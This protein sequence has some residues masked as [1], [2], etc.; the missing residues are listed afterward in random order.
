MRALVDRLTLISG[1]GAP[2]D[3]IRPLVDGLATEVTAFS[4]DDSLLAG[5]PSFDAA[6]DALLDRLGDREWLVGWSLGGL[7]AMAIA[8]RAPERIAGVITLCT[9]PCFVAREAGATGMAPDTFAGFRQ[10]LER[11]AARQWQRFMLLQV[12][13]A[14]AGRQALDSWLTS[15]PPA[16][17]TV[18]IHS[19]AWL[20]EVD[21]RQEWAEVTVPTLH[22]FGRRD[23]LVDPACAALLQSQGRPVRLL[24]NLYHWP[25]GDAATQVRRAIEDCLNEYRAGQAA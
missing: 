16:S 20:A 24:E 21:Q 22:L 13:G 25:F 11:Q 7:L 2:V 10:G 23:P 15:G 18:L 3:M 8:R 12:H 9:H 5:I 14:P 1:W 6:A 19:L 4:L 17:S